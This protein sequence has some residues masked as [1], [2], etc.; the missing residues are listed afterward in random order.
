M[1]ADRAAVVEFVQNY[2]P[3]HLSLM[4]SAPRE[5]AERITNAGTICLGGAGSVVF[6]D[7][8]TGANHV[9]PTGGAAR[10]VSGLS[11]NDFLRRVTWQE[12]D[13]EG[14][15]GLAG[16]TA[17]L[18]RAEG[19]PAHAAA[20]ELRDGRRGGGGHRRGRTARGP[21]RLRRHHALRPGPA[22]LSGGPV[23]QHE[24]VRRGS[25]RRGP[26]WPPWRTAA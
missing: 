2:A 13:A 21:R 5:L 26:R 18:A 12:L 24:P 22:R 15:R 19:L 3:E 25:G 17:R 16:P 1:A 11:V 6:G 8:L 7:Y 23:G 10:R 9:L 20:A 14:A 4:V